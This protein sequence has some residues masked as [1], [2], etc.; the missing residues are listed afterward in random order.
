MK[1]VN[2]NMKKVNLIAIVALSAAIVGCKEEIKETSVVEK[3]EV[4]RVEAAKDQMVSTNISYNGSIEPLKMNNIS[5]SAP[6]RIDA[7]LVEVGDN[8]KRGQIVAKMDRSQQIQQEIS[9]Q[10]LAAD[11]LRLTELFEAGGVSKQTVDQMQAQYDVAKKALD[12]TTENTTLNSPIN[13]VVTARNFDNGDIFSMSPTSTGAAA[14][15]TV[16]QIDSVKLRVNVSENY[17]SNIKTGMPITLRTDSYPN[18]VFNGKVSLI[19]PLVD[20]AS[21]TFTVEVTIPNKNLKLRPGMYT[22]VNINLGEKSAITVSDKAVQKQQGSNERY[23]FVV[24]NGVAKRRTV[25]AA[26]INSLDREILSGVKPGDMIVV[27][28]ASRL[29]D[30]DKVKIVK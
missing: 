10:N 18:E 29:L 15:V 1:I 7:I 16:M 24:E 4:V 28:G 3:V 22:N 2:K 19:Y 13:G 21:H 8:V 26:E 30:G 11:L 6:G 25:V 14:I 9:L 12:F 20:A 27:D 5:S 23:V 17:F